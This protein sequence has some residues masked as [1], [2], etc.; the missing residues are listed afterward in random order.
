M[1]IPGAV[2]G[3]CQALFNPRENPREHTK[4][5]R[6]C[7]Q[8]IGAPW[9]RSHELFWG[10]RRGMPVGEYLSEA[11][12]PLAGT[13]RVPILITALD[14][15]REKEE[16]QQIFRQRPAVTP[17][18]TVLVRVVLSDDRSIAG[19]VEICRKLVQ[20]A[21]AKREMPTWWPLLQGNLSLEGWGRLKRTLGEEWRYANIAVNPF[22][23][24]EVNEVLWDQITVGQIPLGL[25]QGI[26]SDGSVRLARGMRVMGADEEDSYNL[27]EFMT[28]L[29]KLRTAPTLIVLGPSFSE[30]PDKWNL[31]RIERMIPVLRDGVELLWDDLPKERRDIV[32]GL[33]A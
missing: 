33:E 19:I 4:Y 24:D 21:R 12:G 3:Y 9:P 27:F 13:G 15:G 10:Y 31:E 23:S 2:L 7:L 28:K 16:I 18:E 29:S 8:D 30:W 20:N 5:V 1:G 17:G 32:W 22:V 25:A 11:I 26:N 6:S 14:P